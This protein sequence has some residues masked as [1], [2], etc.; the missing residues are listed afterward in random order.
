VVRIDLRGDLRQVAS[1]ASEEFAQPRRLARSGMGAKELDPRPEGWGAL[2]FGTAA[3][4][5]DRRLLAREAHELFRGAGLS[6]TGLAAQEHQ[7]TAS[8]GRGAKRTIEITEKL[9]A[10]DEGRGCEL[11]PILDLGDLRDKT[12]P[13]AANGLEN[14]LASSVVPKH[15]SG[16]KQRLVERVIGD[17]GVRPH[18]GEQLL[19]GDDAP[20]KA[21]QVEEKIHHLLLYPQRPALAAKLAETLVELESFEP[22]DHRPPGIR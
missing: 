14:R 11:G 10:T 4:V 17:D 8:V 6:D 3:D 16:L 12:H 18:V 22:N 21:D 2:G 5:G 15:P 20:P 9:S 7:P 13:A 1:P 19:P